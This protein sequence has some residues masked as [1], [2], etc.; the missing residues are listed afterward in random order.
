MAKRR[1]H[2][3]K[4]HR[5]KPHHKRKAARRPRRRKVQKL[6]GENLELARALG[7]ARKPR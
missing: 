6:A 4:T 1:K 5:R 7:L 3:K 2:K